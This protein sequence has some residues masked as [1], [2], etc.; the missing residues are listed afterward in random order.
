MVLDLCYGKF[1][2]FPFASFDIPQ[3]FSARLYS[4]SYSN[5]LVRAG[6]Q[7]NP[8]GHGYSKPSS[9]MIMIPLPSFYFQTLSS[10]NVISKIIVKA[11]LNIPVMTVFHS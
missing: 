1:H 4:N 7:Q 9:Q 5:S 10:S 3:G 2:S 11:T 8:H 6:S